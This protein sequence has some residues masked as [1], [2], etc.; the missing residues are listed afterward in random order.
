MFTPRIAD[1][2]RKGL[3]T[4]GQLAQDYVEDFEQK[5]PVQDPAPADDLL[6]LRTFSC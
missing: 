2:K 5:W 3:A 6:E 4:Y 1:A